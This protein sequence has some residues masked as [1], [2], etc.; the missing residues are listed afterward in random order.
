MA[1]AFNFALALT[2]IALGASGHPAIGVGMIA[3]A[4]Y[5]FGYEDGQRST[6]GIGHG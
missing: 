6:G 2:G 3:G 1:Y 5:L 4:A